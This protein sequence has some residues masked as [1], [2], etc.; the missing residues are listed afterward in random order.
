MKISEIKGDRALDVF[1]DLIDPAT[2]IMSDK[3]IA[4]AMRNGNNPF[5]IKRA[6]KEHKKSV[7]AI[8]AVLDD[9]DPDT[10]E[11]NVL[12]IPLKLL[13]I[14]NDPAVMSLFTSQVQKEAAPSSGLATEN[15]GEAGE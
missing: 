4:L 15:T 8:L 6:I 2:E 14:L 12:D 11:P 10:Y 13:E 9:Q 1:A 3:Q 7:K 5:A